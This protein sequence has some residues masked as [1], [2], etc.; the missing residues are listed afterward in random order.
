MP[1]R[2][3]RGRAEE[4]TRDDRAARRFLIDEPTAHLRGLRRLGADDIVPVCDDLDRLRIWLL[5][6]AAELGRE[7]DLDA[8]AAAFGGLWRAAYARVRIDVHRHRVFSQRYPAATFDFETL[9]TSAWFLTALGQRKELDRL[10]KLVF[11]TIEPLPSGRLLHN[12]PY[13][14]WHVELLRRRL[15][16]PGGGVPPTIV[17]SVDDVLKVDGAAAMR[18]LM[19]RVVAERARLR[20]EES[21]LVAGGIAFETLAPDV[22]AC[23]R[24]HPGLDE[25]AIAA[26]GYAP[27]DLTLAIASAFRRDPTAVHPVVAAV[28]PAIE[29]LLEQAAK[30]EPLAPKGAKEA[31]APKRSKKKKTPT[32]KR[33]R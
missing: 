19:K 18:R 24:W 4:T 11:S 30:L 20:R 14:Q 16:V 6:V 5:L 22:L 7:G 15:R 33:P 8:A 25:A 2:K 12:D 27:L 1:S 29:R 17:R 9:T 10:A 32:R 21:A 26:T 3:A 31:P 23:A 28:E 13:I